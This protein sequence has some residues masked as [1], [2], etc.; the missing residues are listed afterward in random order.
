[1]EGFVQRRGHD[2]F[3]NTLPKK[4]EYI[5]LLKLTDIQRSLYL[6][7]MEAVG[8]MNPGEKL[9]PLRAFAISCKIWNHPDILFKSQQLKQQQ[10]LQLADETDIDLDLPEIYNKKDESIKNSNKK[11]NNNNNNSYDDRY[12]SGGP[13]FDLYQP[14]CLDQY[15]NNKIGGKFVNN[16]WSN[17]LLED[18]KCDVILI[19]SLAN[20]IYNSRN[21]STGTKLK[22][23]LDN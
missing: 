5:I 17:E 3:I 8:A 14:S 15:V 22:I 19:F 6:S 4:H 7:F 10:Q 18:Y 20:P 21:Q 1:L 12:T 16:D 2:V 13:G 11:R 23:S 9:N